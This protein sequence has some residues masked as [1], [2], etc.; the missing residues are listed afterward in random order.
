ML[1][2][3]NIAKVIT[4]KEIVFTIGLS[5]IEL[6]IGLILRAVRTQHCSSEGELI[7]DSPSTVA[8]LPERSPGCQYAPILLLISIVQKR[9]GQ[10]FLCNRKVRVGWAKVEKR[11]SVGT[12]G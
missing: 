6:L 11:K 2:E 7:S 10:T 4:A 3:V 5:P 9:K 8:M 1:H 12:Q